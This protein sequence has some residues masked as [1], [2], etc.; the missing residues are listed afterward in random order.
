MQNCCLEGEHSKKTLLKFPGFE[1]PFYC[2]MIITF[3]A[4]ADLRSELLRWTFTRCS[5]KINHRAPQTWQKITKNLLSTWAALCLHF[6]KIE[7][8]ACPAWRLACMQSR[9]FVGSCIN[10]SPK[11]SCQSLYHTQ[12]MD[13]QNIQD[14]GRSLALWATLIHYLP[15]LR[16]TPP[17]FAALPC[18]IWTWECRINDEYH[19]M[20]IT[21]CDDPT[22]GRYHCLKSTFRKYRQ[23]RKHIQVY[24]R[25]YCLPSF[26]MLTNLLK[27]GWPFP[28]N[29]SVR[30]LS[31]A[32]IWSLP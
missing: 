12:S 11:V 8:G 28:L 20:R 30:T 24:R 14:R 6:P 23:S 29:F 13:V 15:C 21:Q 31:P 18:R 19:L 9:H 32:V 26:H 4:K 10:G 5:T 25:E 2:N 27:S 1:R 16:R 7:V 17:S 22:P 3:F